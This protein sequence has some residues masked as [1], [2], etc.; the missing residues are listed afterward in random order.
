MRQVLR[1]IGQNR[2]RPRR[3][4]LIAVPVALGATAT[5]MAMTACGSGS[6]SGNADVP[7]LTPGPDAAVAACTELMDRLPGTVLSLARNSAQEPTGI[8]TWGNP[9]ISLTCGATPTGPS[10]DECIDIND[11]NWVF[12]E[13]SAGYTFLTYGRDPAVQVWVP[14]SV[15]RSSATSALVDLEKAVKPLR[16]TERQCSDLADS[17]PSTSPG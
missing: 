1:D 8:A 4:A 16:T 2:V 17:A 11:V 13:S 9:A 5:L 10:T 15:E 3:R 14:A 6:S 7:A 12:S